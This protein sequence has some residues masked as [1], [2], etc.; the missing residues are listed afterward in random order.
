MYIVSISTR[1]ECSLPLTLDSFAIAVLN[2]TYYCSPIY[3]Y[4]YLSPKR[5]MEYLTDSCN[6]T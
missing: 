4:I 6:I 5:S 2:V 1:P 3:L